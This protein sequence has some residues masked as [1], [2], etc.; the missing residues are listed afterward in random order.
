MRI[1]ASKGEI[2]IS[3]L[4]ETQAE[5][6][7]APDTEIGVTENVLDF[8]V[9]SAEYY[10]I[11]LQQIIKEK[12]TGINTFFTVDFYNHET[13]SSS[14]V[15]GN[16]PSF[17]VLFSFKVQVDDFFLQFLEKDGILVDLHLSKGTEYLTIGKAKIEL[18]ELYM[19]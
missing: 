9:A 2:K 6:L 16:Y 4:Q 8:Y 12:L 5:F 1:I 11:T 14:I 13:Q 10:E 18:S 19:R 3:D 15:E 17:N 7:E